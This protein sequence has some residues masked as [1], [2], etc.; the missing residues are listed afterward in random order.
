MPAAIDLRGRVALVTGGSR[1]IGRATALMLASAGASV[2]LSYRKARTEAFAVAREIRKRGGKALVLR[3]DVTRPSSIKDMIAKT[4]DGIA[5][6]DILVN[7]A[8]IWEEDRI[9]T[10]SPASLRHTLSTNLE[11]AMLAASAVSGHMM[12]KGWG[13]IISISSTAALLGEP[14]HS[15]YAASKGGLEAFTRSAAVEL[16]PSG[17]TVNAV[18][19]GW[20]ATEMAEQA[21]NSPAG[22]KLVKEIPLRKVATPEEI[23]WAVLHFASEEASH[24]TGRILVIDGGYSL[25]R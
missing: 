21:L 18:A 7:N 13:R 4:I 22:R 9:P 14:L 12:K 17:I 19:P 25:R 24:T 10:L 5:P 16:G 6:P 1:G 15:P 3:C 23:A 2:A 11:G 8:G 20:T